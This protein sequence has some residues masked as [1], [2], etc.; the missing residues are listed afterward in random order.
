MGTIDVGPGGSLKSTP[1]DFDQ[2]SYRMSRLLPFVPLAGIAGTSFSVSAY[3]L[4]DPNAFYWAGFGLGLVSVFLLSH[5]QK[6]QKS[7]GDVSAYFP[8]A[9]WLAFAPVI[10]AL[11]VIVNCA[12][13]RSPIEEHHQIITGSYVAHGKST[14]YHV[15]FTS[16]RTDRAVERTTVP[17][18]EFALLQ[19]NEPVIVEVHRGLLGVQWIGK[20]RS[21][22]HK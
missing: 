16:W 15:E 2:P 22:L 20:I 4:L 1:H 12:L 9:T 3:K 7:G 6:K 17:Y 19:P 11:V 21:G 13:D 14:S 5:V 18:E 10:V 8:F